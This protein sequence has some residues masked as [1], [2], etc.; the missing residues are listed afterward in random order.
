MNPYYYR[1]DEKCNEEKQHIAMVAN[2]MALNW[3]WNSRKNRFI[4]IPSCLMENNVYC[5]TFYLVVILLQFY[6]FSNGA[7]LDAVA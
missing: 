7:T 6:T 2:G 3:T 1:L 5:N 4:L